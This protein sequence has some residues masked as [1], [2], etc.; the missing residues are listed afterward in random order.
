M[1]GY[2]YDCDF[3]QMLEMPL[4]GAGEPLSLW[5]VDSLE[6]VIGRNIRTAKHCFGCTA[7]AGSLRWRAECRLDYLGQRRVLNVTKVEK[8]KTSNFVR[9]MIEKD[10]ANQKYVAW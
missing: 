9:T 2:L 1:D 8:E 3:N 5:S 10:L 6:D 7:G 4:E